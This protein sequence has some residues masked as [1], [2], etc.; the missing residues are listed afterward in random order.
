MYFGRLAPEK[1]VDTLIRAASQAGVWLQIAGTGP[2]E[3]ELKALADEHGGKIDFLGYCSG[4]KLRELIREARAVVLPSQWYEN[5]PISILEAYASGKPVIGARIGGIP[6][7]IPS[8]KVG[9]LFE[10]GNAEQLAECLRNIQ[11]MADGPLVEMGVHARCHVADNFSRFRY[12]NDFID[13]Y[14][15]LGVSTPDQHGVSA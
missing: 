9:W 3:Q 6:E 13:L 10:S 5:A 15:S 4:D 7:M 2:Y 12:I 1:G 11:D 8:D 14:R